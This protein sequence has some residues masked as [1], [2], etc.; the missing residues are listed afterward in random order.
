MTRLTLLTAVLLLGGCATTI[1]PPAA[2]EQPLPVLVIDHGRHTSLVLPDGEDG[3]VRYAYGDWRYYAEGERGARA[4]FNAL[5]RG[6]LAALGRR[7][8]AGEADPE[9]VTGRIRVKIEHVHLLYVEA[10]AAERLRARLDAIFA[11]GEHA[12][13]YNQMMDLEFVPYPVPYTYRH[14]SNRVVA[15]WL[16]ELGCEVSR[17]PV[18]ANWRIAQ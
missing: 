18:L 7:E 1:T 8:L 5:F 12:R 3:L 16:V 6:T 17:K 14:N 15:E 11:A 2:P 10:A 13:L 9:L 4:T